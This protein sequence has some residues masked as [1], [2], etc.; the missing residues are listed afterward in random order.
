M[1][2]KNF[3][4]RLKNGQ[5]GNAI[6]YILGLA[7]LWFVFFS[8]KDWIKET[9]DA[10]YHKAQDTQYYGDPYLDNAAKTRR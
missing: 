1:G 3:V 5:R 4:Y 7:V 10:R 9:K 2:S 6:V 8:L